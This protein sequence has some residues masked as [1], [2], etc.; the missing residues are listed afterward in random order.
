MYWNNGFRK[1]ILDTAIKNLY[2]CRAF[3]IQSQFEASVSLIQKRMNWS[4][5]MPLGTKAAK[6]KA[7]P[8]FE[9]ID[10]YNKH[11]IPSLRSS[12]ELDAQLYEYAANLF[13]SEA[14]AE[15]ILLTN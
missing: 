12:H 2:K 9:E 15:G 14:E 8:S 4:E 10:R 6:T 11:V 7:R 13:R 5:Y 3:G 1:L